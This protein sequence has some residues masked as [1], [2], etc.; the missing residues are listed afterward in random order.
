MGQGH[1]SSVTSDSHTAKVSRLAIVGGGPRAAMLLERLV[2]NHG[3]TSAGNVRIDVVDPFPAG[4]G[5]IWRNEQSPLLKLNSMA[6]DVSMFTD[7]SVN[8]QGPAVP[9][10]S[11]WEW[12]CQVRAGEHPKIAAHVL[13]P[14]NP[15][16]TE[17]LA[18]TADG[19]PTRKLHSHYLE[20][21]L[22]RTVAGLD[23]KIQVFFHRDTAV[24]L[25]PGSAETRHRL[26]LESGLILQ[27]DQVVLALGHTDAHPNAASV[28]FSDFAANNSRCLTYVPPAYTNDVDLSVVAPGTDVLVSG[29]GLAFI[30]LAVL[31]MQERGGSFKDRPDGSL[32][33]V[34]C[35][36]EPRLHVGSRRGV[37]YLSKIRGSLRGLPGDG[38]HYLTRP[39]VDLLRL[40]HGSLDFRAHLW[41]LIAKESAH[42][43]YRELFTAY[44]QRTALPWDEFSSRFESLDWYSAEREALLLLAVPESRDR[45][46]FETLDNP[47]A[48]RDFNGPEQ[49]HREVRETIQRDLILRDGSENTETVGLFLGLL[50]CYM[51]LGQLISLDE[52]NE[53]SRADISGW[54]HGFFSYVDSG[55]PASRLKE[56]LALEEAGFVRFLG[57]Q[58]TFDIDE[59]SGTFVARGALA[60]HVVRADT[61]I[62]ARLPDSTLSNTSNLLLRALFNRGL[63]TQESTGTGKLLVDRQARAVDL[64][65]VLNPWLFAVGA[66]VSGWN[67]GAFSRPHANAAP[68][69]DTDALARQLLRAVPEPVRAEPDVMSETAFAAYLD[70][71]HRYVG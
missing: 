5:R 50:G 69:R 59:E 49:I 23:P 26:V 33:Y 21:F 62:E 55:P 13:D 41:P 2:A 3:G 57:P 34:S 42:S 54:W 9:G 68:F 31:L 24:D 17:F 1:H 52:V 19:F 47:L 29:M 56:L 8:C 64:H 37:P 6:M 46:D 65:A 63:I 15:V 18:L 7:E 45:L 27:A 39:A 16:H 12:V 71:I 4:A 35:G 28:R 61:L 32:Q 48:S 38:M 53:S 43:Y 10:P 70:S 36:S 44:P 25:V 22:Q 11:L 51:Q 20:W 66:G 60:N 40:Q 58:T 67:S 14:G 30:D